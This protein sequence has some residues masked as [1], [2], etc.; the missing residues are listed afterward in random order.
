MPVEVRRTAT[1]QE[2]DLTGEWR[3]QHFEELEQ[4][5]AAIDLRGGEL[6]LNTHGLTSLDLSCAWAL[7]AFV[8]RAQQAGVRLSYDGTPPDQLRL[9]DATLKQADADDATTALAAAPQ[10]QEGILA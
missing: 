6:R 8:Q 9:L 2:V 4:Q 5:L 3:L 10:P 7:R 1:G